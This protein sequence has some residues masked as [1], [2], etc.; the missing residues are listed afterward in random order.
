MHGTD[1]FLNGTHAYSREGMGIIGGGEGR[2]EGEGEEG[3]GRAQS[4]CPN[5]AWESRVICTPQ[6]YTGNWL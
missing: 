4:G 5:G 1:H 2:G 6:A 3:G